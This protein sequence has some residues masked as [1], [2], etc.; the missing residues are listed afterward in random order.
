MSLLAAVT[1]FLLLWRRGSFHSAQLF[2]PRSTDVYFD[3]DDY[4]AQTTVW[5]VSRLNE[6]LLYIFVNLFWQWTRKRNANVGWVSYWFRSSRPRYQLVVVSQMRDPIII[7]VSSALLLCSPIDSYW[8]ANWVWNDKWII[9]NSY[10]NLFSFS[11]YQLIFCYI[12]SF[13]SLL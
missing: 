13:W 5:S 6:T 4:D 12:L 9:G 3:K 8:T 7:Y 2:W 1:Y 10:A 11:L